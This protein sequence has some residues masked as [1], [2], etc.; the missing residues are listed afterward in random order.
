MVWARGEMDEYRMARRVLMA[1][2]SGRRVLGLNR[3]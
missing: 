3:G 1:K 2:E